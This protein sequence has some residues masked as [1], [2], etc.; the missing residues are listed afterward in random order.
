MLEQHASSCIVMLHDGT[1]RFQKTLL[2][3]WPLVL[4]KCVWKHTHTH[5]CFHIVRS[6]CY[7]RFIWQI[8]FS[9]SSHA[10]AWTAYWSSTLTSLVGAKPISHKYI[11]TTA[12]HLSIDQ[13]GNWAV[14]KTSMMLSLLMI[15]IFHIGC[16]NWVSSSGKEKTSDTQQKCGENCFQ[17]DTN[18]TNCF[19]LREGS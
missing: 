7:V 19:L 5:E 16:N 4:N 6:I 8:L 12:N 10:V 17:K 11:T 18:T 9:K 14:D 13:P 3:W 15:S 1:W 2:V